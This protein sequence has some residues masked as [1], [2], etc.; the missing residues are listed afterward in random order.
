MEILFENRDLLVCVKPAGVLSQAGKP[1]EVT[2]PTLL[3]EY[4]GVPVYPVHR[5]DK[6]VGGVMVYGKTQ[7]AAA[8]LS[9]QVQQGTV[10]K[11]YLAVV[12]GRLEAEEGIL[13][14]LLYHD[15]GKNKSYVVKRQRKGVREARLSYGVLQREED[16]TLVQVRL[17]TGRTHQIRVQFSSRKHPL[18]GD[19]RY[20]GGSGRIALCSVRLTFNVP[21]VGRRSFVRFPAELGGVLVEK[22]LVDM[23]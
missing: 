6:E 2:M 16:K 19:N 14:D 1:S 17:F 20:G 4:C 7:A 12:T 8:D 3:E 15:K 18:L 5:L 11:E 22:N 21:G 9:R 10:K 13:T 23:E